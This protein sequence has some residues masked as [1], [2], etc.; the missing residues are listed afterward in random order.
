[1]RYRSYIA[2]LSLFFSAFSTSLY[3]QSG[4][5]EN[6]AKSKGKKAKA[7]VGK[8]VS[9]I[10][11]LRDHIK[12]WGLEESYN[13]EFLL[14][15]RLN[16]N[17]WSGGVYYLKRDKRGKYHF[18]QLHFSEIKHEKQ[19]KQQSVKNA[20]PEL[21]DA[22]PF[23]FGK[24][25]NLYTLQIGYGKEQLLLPHVIEGN[26]SVSFRWNAGFSL[27]LLKPYYQRL[28]RIDYTQTNPI[29]QL[30]EEK[31][32]DANADLFLK[33]GST[34]GGSKWSKGLNEIQYVPGVYLETAFVITPFP[35]KGF[36]EAITLG[37][38]AAIYTKPLPVM[39]EVKAYNY[40]VSLFAGLAIGKRW[41]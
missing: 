8:K 9:A 27:A 6:P 22:S 18:W 24:I 3:A 4:V 19:I 20:Y 1:M 12:Q 10:K 28:V 37:T 7:A 39:A 40:Q 36:I 21:G 33:S 34:L 32:S 25:N 14:G 16:S 38:N 5:W 15:G 17:G 29:P 41:K 23:V 11:K 35:K 30:S 2:I 26:V 13:R 31:Y